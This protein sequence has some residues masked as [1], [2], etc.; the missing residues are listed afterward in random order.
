MRVFRGVF[1]VL[2]VVVPA[3]VPVVAEH[4]AAA[5]TSTPRLTVGDVSV[6]EGDG[7]K[8]VVHVPIDLTGEDA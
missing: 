7:G 2:A 1:A 5:A 8:V 4:P 3:L 6:A